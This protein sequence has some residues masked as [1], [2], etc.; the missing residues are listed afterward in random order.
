M[1]KLDKDL[2]LLKNRSKDTSSMRVGSLG[3]ILAILPSLTMSH[4]PV[5]RPAE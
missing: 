5:W 4:R 2:W 1:W 3:H